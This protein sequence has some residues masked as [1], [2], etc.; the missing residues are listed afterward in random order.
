MDR[1]QRIKDVI[2]ESRQHY[3]ERCLNSAALK[4]FA[5]DPDVEFVYV[6][7]VEDQNA[8]HGVN[9]PGEMEESA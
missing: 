2:E 1:I 7:D 4:R 5:D 6:S 9:L 3:H 8:P